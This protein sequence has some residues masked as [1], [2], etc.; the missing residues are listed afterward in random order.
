MS[1]M[2]PD[3]FGNSPD[4]VTEEFIPDR[5][6]WT[7]VLLRAIEDWRKGTLRARREAHTFLFLDDADFELVCSSA[8]LDWTSIRARLLKFAPRYSVAS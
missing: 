6:L 5:R 4:S 3:R 8:G 2:A 1:Q 7:A